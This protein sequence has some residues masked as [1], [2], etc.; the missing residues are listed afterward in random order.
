MQCTVALR[1]L[2]GMTSIR[3][4]LAIV[5]LDRDMDASISQTI[6][7]VRRMQKEVYLCKKTMKEM[8]PLD[9]V[10]RVWVENPEDAL[11]AVASVQVAVSVVP[12]EVVLVGEVGDVV[13]VM[14]GEEELCVVVAV[15]VEV[16]AGADVV[17]I[18]RTNK[19]VILIL[20][21]CVVL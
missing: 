17:G 11:V 12:L 18:K 2:D 3:M 9:I 15:V 13:V 21:R 7:V 14:E 6:L 5:T 1:E 10:V 19:A 16:A 4:R 20:F 8:E